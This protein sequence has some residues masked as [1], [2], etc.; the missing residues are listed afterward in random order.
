[1]QRRKLC[2]F[3]LAASA[4]RWCASLRRLRCSNDGASASASLCTPTLFCS[5][6]LPPPRQSSLKAPATSFSP[7]PHQH[8]LCAAAPCEARHRL[9]SAEAHQQRRLLDLWRPCPTLPSP[10]LRDEEG[11]Q[12]ALGATLLACWRR[13]EGM[14]RT[15]EQQSRTWSPADPELERSWI[16]PFSF[17]CPLHH[18]L[19]SAWL[20]LLLLP[21][22]APALLHACP[23][24]SC[25]QSPMIWCC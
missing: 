11:Q 22:C 21:P 3:A 19:F 20:L 23:R 18:L 5:W 1:M 16:S 8:P 24:T 9:C 4:Q 6:P 12:H 7:S 14:P 13:V 25:S 17:F 10:P 15:A 2:L